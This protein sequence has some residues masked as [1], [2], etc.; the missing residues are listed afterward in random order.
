MFILKAKRISSAVSR[1]FIKNSFSQVEWNDGIRLKLQAV[2][3]KNKQYDFKMLW[4]IRF[5]AKLCHKEFS[6][7]F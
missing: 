6:L 3:M 2:W 1:K 5:E 4:K 7:S